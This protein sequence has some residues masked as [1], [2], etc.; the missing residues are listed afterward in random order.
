MTKDLITYLFVID[1]DVTD[2]Y[3]NRLVKFLPRFM[4]DLLDCSWDD[5]SLLVVVCKAKHRICFT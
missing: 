5:T 4:E 3:G 1:F 2:S